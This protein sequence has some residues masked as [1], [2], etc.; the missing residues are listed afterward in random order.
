MP[1][2]TAA[3]RLAAIDIVLS[4]PNANRM[5]GPLMD[6]RARIERRVE[7]DRAIGLAYGRRAGLYLDGESLPEDMA[8]L[9]AL[10]RSAVES[11][12]STITDPPLTV[13]EVAAAAFEAGAD[14]D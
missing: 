8:D 1:D 13:A 4:L 11:T 5:R 6:A 7:H 12:G 3:D 14:R 2:H 10:I 9:G